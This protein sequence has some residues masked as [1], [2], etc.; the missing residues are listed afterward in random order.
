MLSDNGKTCCW[1]IMSLMCKCS[2]EMLFFLFSE[3]TEVFKAD[4]NKLFASNEKQTDNHTLM[5]DT[6]HSNMS[7]VCTYYC[8]GVFLV[9]WFMSHHLSLSPALFTPI[10]PAL[11]QHPPE[12]FEQQI[13]TRKRPQK[14]ALSL[15]FTRDKFCKQTRGFSHQKAST[16]DRFFMI[17]QNIFSTREN[18]VSMI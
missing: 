7:V 11:N 3:D 18:V 2:W 5:L 13:L 17:G 8:R 9:L 16:S 1:F 14:S 4:R 6:L 15:V 12:S 10:A